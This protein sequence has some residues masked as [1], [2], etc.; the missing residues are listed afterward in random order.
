MEY[1]TLL[2]KAVKVYGCFF[3]VELRE[4]IRTGRPSYY[5]LA[6][7]FENCEHDRGIPY[8]TLSDAIRGFEAATGCKLTEE[9]KKQLLQIQLG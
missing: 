7:I 1:K 8:D 6:D 9:M 4:H 2:K 5:Q 3:Y